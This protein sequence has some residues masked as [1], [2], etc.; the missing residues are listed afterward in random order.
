[1]RP[2][3]RTGRRAIGALLVVILSMIVVLVIIGVGQRFLGS[4][5]SNQTQRTSVGDLALELAE[6]AVEEALHQFRT[7]AND[8][9]T[10][11]FAL[12]RK[13]VYVPSLGDRDLTPFIETPHLKKI[14]S[15]PQYSKF[16]LRDLRVEI[17]YQ[18]QFGGLGYERFGIVKVRAQVRFDLS[19]TESVSREVEAGV[20]FK[21]ALC[22]PPRPFDQM[23]LMI[24]IP[25]A[26]PS[27]LEFAQLESK[28]REL[29]AL[30]K[31]THDDAQQR[32][33]SGNTPDA[34]K[35]EYREIPGLVNSVDTWQKQLPDLPTS[36]FLLWGGKPAPQPL[37]FEELFILKKLEEKERAD[38]TPARR[39]VEQALRKVTTAPDDVQAHR[40]LIAAYRRRARALAS[41]LTVMAEQRQHFAAKS[42]DVFDAVN[43]HEYKLYERHWGWKT[44]YE[45]SEKPDDP[46]DA[47]L[48]RLLSA[49]HPISG[50][51]KL[52][53]TA[54][55]VR[56]ANVDIQGK[57][58]ILTGTGGVTLANVNRRERP[59]DLLTIVS[60]GGPI[61]VS[62]DVH[63]VVIG[64]STE[65]R[66][67][68][69]FSA[70]PGSTIHGGLV[71]ET[72]PSD[73]ERQFRIVRDDKYHS[74]TSE[75]KSPKAA[76]A[77]YYYIATSPRFVYRRVRR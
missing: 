26:A 25:G 77:D 19:L 51:L 72:L 3:S 64:G 52:N 12:M 76:Y 14:L 49:V 27:E 17:P 34:V 47:Q 37:E 67:K 13:D 20:G 53:N 35:D 69:T 70:A 40:D 46:I 60:L 58:I 1:M 18:R 56:L 21:V 43:G 39:E 36:G 38:L 50:I 44:F 4:A 66:Q 22:G 29:F 62:G 9:A 68:A 24:L 74:G 71:L 6:S 15:E 2:P 59:A 63:A 16:Y 11:I 7:K 65:S 48:S 10:P 73:G 8:P 42:G 54:K 33:E 5:V 45:L 55:P 75:E 23:A 30:V 28:K 57:L 61:S 31:E 32:A 41:L